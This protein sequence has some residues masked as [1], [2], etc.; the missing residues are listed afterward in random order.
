MQLIIE[1]INHA[2]D[3]DKN[4]IRWNETGKFIIDPTLYFIE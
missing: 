2:T 1:L 4:K 3:K